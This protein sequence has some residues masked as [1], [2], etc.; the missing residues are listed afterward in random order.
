MLFKGPPEV[1]TAVACSLYPSPSEKNKYNLF[2]QLNE[3]SQHHAITRYEIDVTSTEYMAT[4][5]GPSTTE[6]NCRG[7]HLEQQ[8][9]ISMRGFNCGNQEGEYDNFTLNLQGK[10]LKPRIRTINDMFMLF[11]NGT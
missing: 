4:C 11:H 1:P 9:K 2:F 8:Y 7:L 3:F 6:Y 5:S 10:S